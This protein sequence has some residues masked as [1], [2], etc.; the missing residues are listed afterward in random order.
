MALFGAAAAYQCQCQ[1]QL[2]SE[3]A[4]RAAASPSY[5][6][7]GEPRPLCRD[8]L[9]ELDAHSWAEEVLVDAC[10]P[11]V[12]SHAASLVDEHVAAALRRP[13]LAKLLPA[14]AD[15]DAGAGAGAGAAGGGGD[16]ALLQQLEALLRN[17]YL[18]ALR[19]AV[20]ASC[21]G[22]WATWLGQ[23]RE[24]CGRAMRFVHQPVPPETPLPDLLA[25]SD[26]DSH[27]IGE[28]VIVRVPQRPPLSI[29]LAFLKPGRPP[30][31]A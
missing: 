4:G 16:G 13:E 12:R 24:Q 9:L 5:A 22:L 27:E 7:R 28:E 3:Q 25:S 11:S 30:G 26:S 19:D 23:L 21:V 2:D 8:S 17:V 14:G 10:L 31:L 29:G 1:R 15:A 6:R 18:H 20:R